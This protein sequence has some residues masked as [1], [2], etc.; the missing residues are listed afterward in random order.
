MRQLW[1]LPVA[2]LFVFQSCRDKEPDEVIEEDKLRIRLVPHFDG[3]AFDFNTFYTTDEGYSIQFNKLNIIFTNIKNGSNQLIESAVY[4]FENNTIVWQGTGDYA[5]FTSLT[6]N[7]GVSESENHK[8]PAAR[9]LDDPLA[10]GNTGDMHWGWNPGYIFLMIEGKADT[11][12]AQTGNYNMNFLYHVGMNPLLR[13]FS[14]EYISWVKVNDHLH[15]ATFRV[16]LAKIFNGP[17]PI[18][19]RLERSSHTS[20]G[21]EALSSKIINNFISALIA[22]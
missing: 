6:G 8:D 2:I 17:E 19:I 14:L 3:S 16:D 10:I 4:R 5:Q 18:D 20:P 22:D 11:T 13:T 15:E 9:S 7:I 12:A 21:E 1:L